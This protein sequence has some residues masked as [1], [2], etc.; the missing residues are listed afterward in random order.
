MYFLNLLSFLHF[1]KIILS[2]CFIHISVTCHFASETLNDAFFDTH[3]TSLHPA[4]V[5]GGGNA[6]K[7]L[8]YLPSERVVAGKDANELMVTSQLQSD[9]EYESKVIII[10]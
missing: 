3:P 10:I 5:C 7:N 9:I 4:L 8:L 2:S 6:F 1:L